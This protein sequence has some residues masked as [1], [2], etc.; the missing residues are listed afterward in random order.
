MLARSDEYLHEDGKWYLRTEK[1][2]KKG[3]YNDKGE[4]QM[5]LLYFRQR[6]RWPT[7]RQLRDFMGM[8]SS[9]LRSSALV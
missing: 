5:A 4:A 9:A 2:V 1:G 6:T 3:P 8:D 7:P